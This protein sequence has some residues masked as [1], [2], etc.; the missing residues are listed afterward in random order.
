MTDLPAATPAAVAYPT[1]TKVIVVGIL[2]VAIAAFAAAV[3]RS[4]TSIEE[5]TMVSGQVGESSGNEG[6]DALLPARGASIVAQQRIGIDLRSGW[7]A[8][9][10]LE[11][12]DGDSV[13]LPASELIIVPELAQFFFEPADGAVVERLPGGVNCL[14][15]VIWDLSRGR[16]ASERTERWC[17]SVV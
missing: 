14:R 6:V 2:A 13:P 15:A 12:S 7:T 4:D 8:E 10:T 1:R 9:L 3:L 17:F 16:E 5:E 11:R